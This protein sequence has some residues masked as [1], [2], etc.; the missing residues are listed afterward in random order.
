MLLGFFGRVSKAPQLTDALDA[1]SQRVRSIAQRVSVAT[2]KDASGFSIPGSAAGES[3]SVNLE[4]EMT[5]LAD[6]QL[7]YETSAKLL[8]KTYA[9]IRLSIRE[10]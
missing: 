10:R 4:E 7:R 1:G 3:T 5:R 8:E 6:E 9:N 2:L